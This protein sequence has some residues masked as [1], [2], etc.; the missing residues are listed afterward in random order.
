MNQRRLIGAAAASVLLILLAWQLAVTF[1]AYYTLEFDSDLYFLLAAGRDL[2][3]TGLGRVTYFPNS[4]EGWDLVLWTYY[5]PVLLYGALAALFDISFEQLPVVWLV[6]LLAL[7]ATVVL[8]FRRFLPW[9]LALGGAAITFADPQFWRLAT[10]NYNLMAMVFGPW[11]VL[12]FD[13][14]SRSLVRR[15]QIQYAAV[16]GALAAAAVLSFTTFGLPVVFAIGGVSLVHAFT[17]RRV[18]PLAA[19]LA[20]GAAIAAAS[21]L[22]LFLRLGP[23]RIHDLTATLV[24]HYT[25]E[26]PS[27]LAGALVR[28]GYF[29]A[30]LIVSPW[31]PSLLPAGI[32]VA[33]IL[34]VRQRAIADLPG[35]TM[36]QIAAAMAL[37]WIVLGVLLP[38]NITA[39]RMGSAL[40][41]LVLAT[42]IGARARAI[43]RT[44]GLPVMVAAAA[45][46]VV[47]S[48]YFLLGLPWP[49]FGVGVA[50]AVAIVLAGAGYFLTARSV[51]IATNSGAVTRVALTFAAAVAVILFGITVTG[52]VTGIAAGVRFASERPSLP[53][54][55]R[56]A[57]P[58]RNLTAQLVKPHDRILTNMAMPEFF[59][60]DA[61]LQLLRTYRGL[62]N[63]ATAMPADQIILFADRSAGPVDPGY[64]DLQPGSSLYF[65]GHVY[66]ILAATE[67]VGDWYALTGDAG[68]CSEAAAVV[69]PSEWIPPDRVAA[70]LAWRRE[71]GLGVD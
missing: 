5:L 71:R 40:P 9:S 8:L 60:P 57:A 49:P 51:R 6:E 46:S 7:V 10:Q 32:A 44:V 17:R 48:A 31:A 53:D 13:A 29:A 18:L 11:A 19:F 12:A 20:G 52:A 35:R 38:R 3:A 15:S 2:A 65:Q 25:A 63:G 42:M 23:D 30:G 45:A 39:P 16:S 64:G 56:L 26:D 27:G 55:V 50:A 33:G 34:L 41:L 43:P 47:A 58:A 62:T 1:R 28:A 69:Y 4:T 24:Y 54:W 14:G 36:I 70:Y 67:L 66:C 59:P 61:P 22:D 37:A 21:A 68:S